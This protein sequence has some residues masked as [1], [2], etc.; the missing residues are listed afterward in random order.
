MK[1]LFC[2]LAALW[3]LPRAAL[4]DSLVDVEIG[5]LRVGEWDCVHIGEELALEGERSIVYLEPFGLSECDLDVRFQDEP[6]PT[7]A[8][9][10][11][12]AFALEK[13]ARL[14]RH[15]EEQ[16]IATVD[17]RLL[18]AEW[19]DWNGDTAALAFRFSM[20]FDLSGIGLDTVNPCWQYHLY[21]PAADGA[22]HVTL[23]AHSGEDLDA[24]LDEFAARFQPGYP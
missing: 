18:H 7:R 14:S 1:K 6:L 12:E 15:M 13:M 21:F 17:P 11:P 23:S 20:S 2:L 16:R 5:T 22:Y 4:A 8:F 3:L 10:D 24:L 19:L 9:D